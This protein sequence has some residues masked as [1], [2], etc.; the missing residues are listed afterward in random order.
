M[1]LR[2]VDRVPP[3]VDVSQINRCV[4]RLKTV[5]VK[6]LFMSRGAIAFYYVTQCS[7]NAVVFKE[8]AVD[9]E[10]MHRASH[11]TNTHTNIEGLVCVHPGH[12]IGIM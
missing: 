8:R 6:L 1:W 7:G 5:N 9:L 11:M 3:A 10:I 4:Q 12:F 2:N